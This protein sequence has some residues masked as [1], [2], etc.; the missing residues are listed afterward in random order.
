MIELRKGQ[1][2]DLIYAT[3]QNPMLTPPSTGITAPVMNF[4]AGEVR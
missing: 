3:L 2:E 4:A 1:I